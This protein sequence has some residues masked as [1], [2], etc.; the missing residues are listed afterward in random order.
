MLCDSG[1]VCPLAGPPTWTSEAGPSSLLFTQSANIAEERPLTN[2][3]HQSCMAEGRGGDVRVCWG[4][5]GN[6]QV[7]RGDEEI[8]EGEAAQNEALT[9]P[10]RLSSLLIG[11]W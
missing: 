7:G 6:R 9:G 3:S 5:I 11:S 1:D 4:G 8:E 10:S 2:M